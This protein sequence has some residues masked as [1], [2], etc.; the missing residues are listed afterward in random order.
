MKNSQPIIDDIDP[1]DLSAVFL[2]EVGIGEAWS[3]SRRRREVY[4]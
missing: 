2:A 3:L 1:D 4:A